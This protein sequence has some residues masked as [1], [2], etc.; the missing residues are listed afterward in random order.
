VIAGPVRR[1]RLHGLRGQPE[2]LREPPG[3]CADV[4]AAGPAAVPDGPVEAG[5]PAVVGEKK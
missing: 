2:Q 1:L 3:L 5:L 4:R